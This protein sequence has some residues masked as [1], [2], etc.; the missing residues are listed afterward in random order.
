MTGRVAA[1]LAA[2]LA[3]FLPGCSGPDGGVS[4]PPPQAP[5]TS[6]SFVPVVGGLTLPV[7]VG[8]A[9]DGSRRI[10]IVEQAGRILI[11]DNGSVLPAPFLDIRARVLSGGEQGLFSVAFPPGFASKGHFY[12]HYTRVPDGSTVVSRYLVTADP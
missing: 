12:V 10:F 9:G 4:V 5:P 1:V 7:H 11:L 6:V 3:A 8:H 2:T